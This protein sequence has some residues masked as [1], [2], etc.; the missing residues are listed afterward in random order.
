MQNSNN[1]NK[2]PLNI[3]LTRI[4]YDWKKYKFQKKNWYNVVVVIIINNNIITIVICFMEKTPK[5]K[6]KLRM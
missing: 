3:F 6:E 2:T 5:R 1:N 4:K